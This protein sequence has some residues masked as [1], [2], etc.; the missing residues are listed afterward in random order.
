M[1]GNDNEV[2]VTTRNRVCLVTINRPDRRNARDHATNLRM[3]NAIIDADHD[4][5]VAMIAITG[6]GDKAFCSGA[7]LRADSDKFD[8]AKHIKGPVD[9]PERTLMEVILDTRKPVMAI[10]NGPAVAGGFELMLACDIRV[11][12]DTAFFS[13]P[14]AKR[15]RGAHFASVVLPQFVPSAIA[16]EWL[17]TGRRIPVEEAER[18]GLINR[19]V[20]F[21]KL[22]DAAMELAA[23]VISSAPLSL[24]KMKMTA[25]RT[26]G[27]PL[28]AGLRLDV[29]PNLYETEDQ[30]EGVRAYLEKRK[31]QWQGR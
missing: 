28:H 17:F 10:I 23:E 26:A 9:H 19:I 21:S 5:E 2:L 22:I 25:R 27:M 4:P 18:W 1:S 13:L 8:T 12:A 14:E 11:A 7:D 15:G 31:P 6:A 20:P 3:M 24:Q 16:L 29:G 30:K